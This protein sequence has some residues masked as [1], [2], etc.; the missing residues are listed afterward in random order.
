M[1]MLLE[2]LLRSSIISDEVKQTLWFVI[3]QIN[4]LLSLSNDLIDRCML[5]LN[6][7]KIKTS[8]FAPSETLNFFQKMFTPQMRLVDCALKM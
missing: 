2:D 8:K 6:Q 5:E 3:S 4:L 1:L 7:F